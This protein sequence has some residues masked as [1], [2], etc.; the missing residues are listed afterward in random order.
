MPCAA[1]PAHASITRAIVPAVDAGLEGMSAY[2]AME[3][4]TAE[5]LD[6]ALRHL[7][8]APLDRAV[9]ILRAIAEA[10]GRGGVGRRPRPRRAP[11]TRRPSC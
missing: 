1:C 6:V 8:P 4:V 11:P 10:G 2:L 5:T 3:Y 9:P 7:A